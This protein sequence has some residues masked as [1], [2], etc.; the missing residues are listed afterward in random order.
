MDLNDDIHRRILEVLLDSREVRVK[1]PNRA[2]HN[3]VYNFSVSILRTCRSM[4]G[5]GVEV[6]RSNKFMLISTTSPLLPTMLAGHDVCIWTKKLQKFKSYCLRVHI[7]SRPTATKENHFFLLCA[8][9]VGKLVTALR[10]LSYEG[11]ADPALSAN[12]LKLKFQ[13]IKFDDQAGYLT[14]KMQHNLISPFARMYGALSQCTFSGPCDLAFVK[15]L[16]TQVLATTQWSRAQARE[17]FQ[18]MVQAKNAGDKLLKLGYCDS[19][20]TS[21]ID[22]LMLAGKRQ[23]LAD[24]IRFSDDTA[25]AEAYRQLIFEL[26]LGSDLC[27]LWLAQRTPTA[28]LKM[29]VS[30][31]FNNRKAMYCAPRE[32]PSSA[33]LHQMALH[34]QIFALAHYLGGNLHGCERYLRLAK[35]SRPGL[36]DKSKK[37]LQSMLYGTNDR[38][39]ENQKRIRMILFGFLPKHYPIKKITEPVSTLAAINQEMYAL[40]KLLYTGDHLQGRVVQKEGWSH[41]GDGEIHCAFSPAMIDMRIASQL[42]ACANADKK[43]LRRPDIVIGPHICASLKAQQAIVD[44]LQLVKDAEAGSWETPISVMNLGGMEHRIDGDYSQQEMKEQLSAIGVSSERMSAITRKVPGNIPTT[45]CYSNEGM[46]G[47]MRSMTR[48]TS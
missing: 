34:Y 43:G 23:T 35:E 46:P 30:E 24:I 12:K 21:Y 20:N 13:L 26:Q 32:Y 4:Y 2:R 14:I 37:E 42:E 10:M 36:Y 44:R 45:M 31:I 6:L 16:E 25:L 9:E 19:A 29:L 40:Q 18:L 11:V 39:P 33:S 38:S 17:M 41:E 22:A 5:L 8:T 27:F 47:F 3:T 7:V 28:G 15:T 1:G 48:D